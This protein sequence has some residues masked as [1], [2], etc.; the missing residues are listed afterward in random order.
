[1]ASFTLFPHLPTELRLKIW[2]HA[3]PS[4]RLIDLNLSITKTRITTARPPILLSVCAESREAAQRH[5]ARAFAT[6]TS[7]AGTWV[8]PAR[9]VVVLCPPCSASCYSAPSCFEC[10]HFEYRSRLA[11]YDAESARAV[12]NVAVYELGLEGLASVWRFFPGVRRLSVVVDGHW[13]A[14]LER[15]L[16]VERNVE[17]LLE[18]AR[19]EVPGLVGMGDVEVSVVMAE[20]VRIGAGDERAVVGVGVK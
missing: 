6:S 9:D 4:P 1:M 20:E 12:R 17:E 3:L 5:Y 7:P 14:F 18:R 8:D 11:R 15:R 2:D 19:E 16:L 13:T 10:F